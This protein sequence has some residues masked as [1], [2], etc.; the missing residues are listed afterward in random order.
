MP[1]QATGNIENIEGPNSACN[2][3]FLNPRGRNNENVSA[4]ITSNESRNHPALTKSPATKPPMNGLEHTQV[5][6]G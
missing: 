6:D 5:L 1:Q 3:A 4:D 2:D